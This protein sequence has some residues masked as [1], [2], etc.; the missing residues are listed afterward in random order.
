MAAKK[1]L[2]EQAGIQPTI[3]RPTAETL[4]ENGIPIK[5]A[6]FHKTINS[7]VDGTPEYQYYHPGGTNKKSRTARMWYTPTGLL[8]EQS[9]SLDQTLRHKL[10]PLANVSDTELL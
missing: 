2:L 5:C 1:E 4:K 9:G 7:I 3:S 8:I 10:I 6:T